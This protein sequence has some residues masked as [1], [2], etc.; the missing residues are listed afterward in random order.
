MDVDVSPFND[1]RGWTAPVFNSA[2][3]GALDA[4]QR[5]MTRSRLHLFEAAV[6]VEHERSDEEARQ[7]A[8]MAAAAKRATNQQAKQAEESALAAEL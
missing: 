3:W 8:K 7:L 6:S 1:D 4:A 5:A 2:E